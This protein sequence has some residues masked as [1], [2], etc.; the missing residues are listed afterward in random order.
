MAL[1]DFAVAHWRLNEVSNRPALDAVASRDLTQNGLIGATTGKLAGARTFDGSTANYFSRASDSVLQTGDVDFSIS[2]WVKFNS[3]AGSQ[4]LFSKWDT[5]GFKEWTIRYDAFAE[6]LRFSVYSGGTEYSVLSGGGISTGVWYFIACVYDA[7][8]D[9]VYISVNGSSLVDGVSVLSTITAGSS[10]VFMG[11]RNGGGSADSESLDGAMD[12]WTFFK[13]YALADADVSTLYN[14][15]AGLD[16]PFTVVLHDNPPTRQPNQRTNAPTVLNY[17]WYQQRATWPLPVGYLPTP[18]PNRQASQRVDQPADFN[19]LWYKQRRVSPTPVEY[20]PDSPPLRQASQRVDPLPEFNYVWY[21][22]FRR[23]PTPSGITNAHLG[24]SGIFVGITAAHLGIS[25]VRND[26][27]GYNIY[28]GVDSL[29]DLSQPPSFSQTLPVSV[30]TTPPMSGT[31]TYYVLVRAQNQFGLESQNQWTKSFTIDSSGNLA[32]PPIGTP[33]TLQA[34]PQ[35]AGFVR[36]L[37]TYPGYFLDEYKANTW[38]IWISVAEPDVL[39]DIPVATAPV[40]GSGL[41]ANIGSFA[42][43]QTYQIAVTLF[44]AVD[45]RQSEPIRGEVTFPPV[46]DEVDPVASGYQDP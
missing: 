39:L 16:Y 37:A 13:G 9:T 10:A 43:G 4:S 42:S 29:P 12:S 23:Q 35:A 21:E 1:V 33:Q 19:A 18:P 30:A 11:G 24:I 31:R 8:I 27:A 6:A 36:L 2:G 25:G 14:G 7:T 38:N 22:Q 32:L 46:P 28:V 40:Q 41:A 34:F 26:V 17:V 5:E 3:V 20:T 44:R 45:G 15:G